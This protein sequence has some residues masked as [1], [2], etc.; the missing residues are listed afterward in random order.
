[1]A[2]RILVAD[3][4]QKLRDTTRAI[5]ESR[6]GWLVVGEAVNGR[7]RAKGRHDSARRV[8]D[9]LLHALVLDGISAI[10]EIHRLVA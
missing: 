6:P 1:M 9:R 10:P 2:L 3:D 4:N 5:L 7:S 8:G